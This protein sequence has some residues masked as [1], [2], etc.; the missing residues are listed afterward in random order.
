MA[1][2][3]SLEIVIDARDKA[4]AQLRTLEGNLSKVAKSKAFGIMAAGAKAAALGVATLAGG[5]TALGVSSISAFRDSEVAMARFNSTLK[6]MGPAGEKARDAIL[7]SADAATKLGFDD[8]DAA[9]SVAKLFQRTGDLNQAMK[10]NSLAMDIARA[11]QISLGDAS[12]IVNLALSG[13]A[14]ALKEYGIELKDGVK[15]MKALEELQKSVAG[16][17]EAYSKTTSGQL[18]ILSVQWGNLKESLGE[19]L[20]NGLG[21]NGW[22]DALNKKISDDGFQQGIR[23]IAEQISKIPQHF[24]DA[25]SSVNAF[26][27]DTN[28]VWQFIK[29]SLG[30]AFVMLR[31][32]AVDSWNKIREAIIPITPEAVMFGKVI[33]TLVVGAVILLINTLL[34]L[35]TIGMKVVT[36]LIQM[37]SSSVQFFRNIFG[38]FFSYLMG[39]TQNAVASMKKAFQSLRD[40]FSSMWNGLKDVVFT[41]IKPVIDLINKAIAGYNKLASKAGRGTIS[42]IRLEGRATGGP[43]M[44]GKP[45]MVGENGPEMFIPSSSGTIQKNVN[46]SR[47]VEAVFNFDF[48]GAFI[49][50]KESF[51]R[52]IEAR[53]GRQQE[54]ARIGAI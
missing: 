50:D 26:F 37:F 8:E 35:V 18:E 16:Q 54:L 53:L 44:S 51:M 38:G 34:T 31:D 17:A 42:E 41:A 1:S 28:V 20:V 12:K 11:K 4:S 21:V 9:E 2:A 3:A 33:G 23:Q 25:Q 49:G 52:E 5:V 7:K 40:F 24:R 32:T 43:V 27:S 10:L 30:P 13:N 6:A 36:T 19:T 29:D 47:Q 14:R 22:L 15:P 48:S 39:D 45:Y 46:N